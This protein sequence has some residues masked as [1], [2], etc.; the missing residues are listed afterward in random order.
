MLLRKLDSDLDGRISI[1]DFQ[2]VLRGSAPVSCSTPV[3]SADL[4]RAPRRVRHSL[5]QCSTRTVASLMRGCTAQR[6]VMHHF[7]L[8]DF[9]TL[10]N[11]IYKHSRYSA[12]DVMLTSVF[13]QVK[14]S[15]IFCL[16][17]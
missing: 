7:L 9:K 14:N 2:K 11:L 13:C 8:K 10:F 5:T 3:R 1:M 6:D 17:V 12:Q 15:Y 16:V 4:Q